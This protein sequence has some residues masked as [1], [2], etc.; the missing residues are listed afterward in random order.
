MGPR[1]PGLEVERVNNDGDYEP[2][3][4]VWARH[5]QQLNNTRRNFRVK[6]GETTLTLSQAAQE[7][8][9]NLYTLRG[10]LVSGLDPSVAMS[11]VVRKSRPSTK[12]G[13]DAVR[14]IR[15]LVRSGVPHRR[16]SLMFGCDKSVVS[17]IA[18]GKSRRGVRDE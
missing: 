7:A 16:V 13:D 18:A 2:G 8:G 6:V 12:L 17:R 3:N 10:R 11:T 15:A 1:P 4:C 14:E 5:R 9:M